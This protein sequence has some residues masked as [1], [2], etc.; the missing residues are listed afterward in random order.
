[1]VELIYTT[2]NERR[3]LGPV[4]HIAFY[5]DNLTA[6]VQELKSFGIELDGAIREV[7]GG[8]MAFF[9]G[10]DGERLEYFEVK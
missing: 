5:V 10:P 9:F 4:D 7:S 1:M 6:K 8:K 2:K 3:T